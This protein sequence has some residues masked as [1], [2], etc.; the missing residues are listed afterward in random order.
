M[1]EV[2]PADDER[3]SAINVSNIFV[4]PE[5]PE[6]S[7]TMA[8]RYDGVHRRKTASPARGPLA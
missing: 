4:I 3:L 1:Y 8:T 5:T 6:D 2:W 7:E